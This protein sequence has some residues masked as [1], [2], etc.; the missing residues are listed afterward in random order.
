MESVE[1]TLVFCGPS[2]DDRG[3]HGFGFSQIIVPGPFNAIHEHIMAA[4]FRYDLSVSARFGH[5]W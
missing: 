2:R 1:A 3:S 5:A 4:V